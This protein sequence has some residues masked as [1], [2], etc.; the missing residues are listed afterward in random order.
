MALIHAI[1][2]RDAL[3]STDATEAE[4]LVLAVDLATREQLTPIFDNTVGFTRHR[5]AEIDADISG[6]PYRTDDP[7]WAM[8]TLFYAAAHRDSEVLRAYLDV[9]SVLASP[10]QSLSAPGMVPR[11]LEHGSNVPRYFLPG[12]SRA[13]LL[14]TLNR[15]SSILV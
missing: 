13:E 3:R 8:S 6:I 10:E 2:L 12:P 9:A 1:I 15:S 7:G 14:S 4:N 5:L 11:V